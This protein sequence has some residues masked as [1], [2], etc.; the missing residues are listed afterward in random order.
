MQE[1]EKDCRRMCLII[2]VHELMHS[3]AHHKMWRR[4]HTFQIMMMSDILKKT[5]SFVFFYFFHRGIFN[6]FVSLQFPHLFAIIFMKYGHHLRVIKLQSPADCS[7]TLQMA[8]T[9]P[10]QLAKRLSL[11]QM[12]PRLALEKSPV[13]SGPQVA[14]TLTSTSLTRVMG[15]SQSPSPHSSQGH[16]QL[17]SNLVASWF[18]MAP[19]LYR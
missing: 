3:V 16:T 10:S 11:Q 19:I 2:E 12:L 14:V 15:H 1:T 7:F 6:H 8:M 17:K 18:P 5:N 13:A 4:A 9:E